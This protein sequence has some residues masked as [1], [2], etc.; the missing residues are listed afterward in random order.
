MSYIAPPSP[1][2]AEILALHAAGMQ[3]AAIVRQL[4]VT[5]GVVAGVISRWGP[6]VRLTVPTRNPFPPFGGCLYPS[7]HAIMDPGF[8]FCGEPVCAPESAWCATHR[9]VVYMR[10]S[11]A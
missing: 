9:K 6:P 7:P 4:G 1:F 10:G 8:S 11:A 2:R 5:K 3:P